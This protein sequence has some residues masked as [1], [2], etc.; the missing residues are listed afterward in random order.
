M[1]AS[2][3]L[4]AL[5]RALAHA[6]YVGMPDVQYMRRDYETAAKW[7]PEQR[8]K[9]I[10]EQS[11]PEVAAQ[12]RPDMSECVVIAMFP[13][14]WGSTALGF[15]GLGGA[16]MTEA[17]TIALEGPGRDVAIYWAGRFAYRIAPAEVTEAQRANLQA[18]LAAS[19]TVSCDE[20]EARYGA[21]LLQG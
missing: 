15:G 7:T 1:R 19:R 16:A 12:R 9:A 6:A 14:M 4:D 20:A 13:Q 8:A 18:D 3:S 11:F 5:A 21:T 10:Q 2:S 17:Y